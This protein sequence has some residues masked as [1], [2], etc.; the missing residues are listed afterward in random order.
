[1]PNALLMHHQVEQRVLSHRH[2]SGQIAARFL[3]VMPRWVDSGDVIAAADLGLVQAANR[4]EAG[5]GVPF[6]A[7]ARLR[8]TGS[9]RDELRATDPLSRLARQRRT[10]LQRETDTLTALLQRTVTAFEVRAQTTVARTLSHEVSAAH[11]Y[12]G[13]VA[14]VTPGV[15]EVLLARERIRF[16]TIAV[17]ALPPP[18]A[19]VVPGGAHAVPLR[20]LAEKFGV[21]VSTVSRQRTVALT[22]L[23]AAVAFYDGTQPNE[24][25]S[26]RLRTYLRRVTDFAR[27]SA[28]P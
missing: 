23:S 24:P 14:G 26:P 17:L 4:F 25:S 11:T 19:R 16:V 13:H 21:S 15:D 7:Y 5:Y 12:N 2:L 20:I 1:M 6:G 27:V 10:Q 3:A 18:L 8:I 28:Q 22:W 9:V